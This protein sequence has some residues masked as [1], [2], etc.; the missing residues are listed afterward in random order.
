L[1][2]EDPFHV[3]RFDRELHGETRSH[4]IGIVEG[5]HVL[6]LVNTGSESDNEEEIVRIISA[7]KATPEER[8]IYSED[9]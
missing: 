1:V 3:S 7:R 8:R 4:T 9:G 5:I 2:F 6:L